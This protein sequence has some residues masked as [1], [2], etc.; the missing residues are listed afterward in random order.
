MATIGSA[1]I[2]R[3]GSL[4][5]VAGVN[6]FLIELANPVT[7]DG[8]V[9]Q[10]DA[11]FGVVI[12]GGTGYLVTFTQVSAGIF[13]SREYVAVTFPSVVGLKTWTG[14]ALIVKIGDFIGIGLP[15]GSGNLGIDV[16][17]S[18]GSGVRHNQAGLT[19]PITSKAFDLFTNS[20]MSL[21]GTTGTGDIFPTD[22]VTRV[23][24]IIHRY[25]RGV[26][27]MELGFGDVVA[28]F[29]IPE[30]SG[31]SQ[32]SYVPE[33]KKAPVILPSGI[34]EQP[35]GQPAPLSITQY[36]YAYETVVPRA[37]LPPTTLP[38]AAPTVQVEQPI[39]LTQYAKDILA[40]PAGQAGLARQAGIQQGV[41][42]VV[43]PY[44][45]NVLRNNERAAT[46]QTE[47]QKVMTAA[48]ASGI[49][50]YARTV[51]IKRAIAIRAELTKLYG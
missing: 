19:L 25:N 51:L 12:P 17:G 37:P 5:N 46:L 40:S 48:S 41:E 6:R 4:G 8:Y 24:S 29:N 21:Q 47:L 7:A 11:Y 28:D 13:S 32:K 35:V 23:T 49:T 15:A 42:A 50:S 30:V 10:V 2:N 43:T 45:I 14:F 3:V 22:P 44:A 1:A 18:G 36:D 9:T 26:Y 16:A 27:N 34:A 39:Q 38:P 20:I 31:T 33:E